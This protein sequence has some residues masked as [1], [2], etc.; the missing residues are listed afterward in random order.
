MA[1]PMFPYGRTKVLPANALGTAAV[2]GQATRYYNEVYI[3]GLEQGTIWNDLI[4]NSH[5]GTYLVPIPGI[6]LP[7]GCVEVFFNIFH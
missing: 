7:S 1:N 6:H 4:K 2:I 3:W 5:G